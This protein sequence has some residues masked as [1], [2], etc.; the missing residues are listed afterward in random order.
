MILLA[1]CDARYC[2]S[3]ADVGEC[4]SNNDSGVLSNS[5]MGKLFKRN[6]VNIPNPSEIEGTDVELPY[7][8][9]GDEIFTLINWLMRPFSRKPL[10]NEKRKVFNYRLSRARRIIEN[11][12]GILVARWRILQRPIEGTP[13]RVEKYI[14][15]MILYIINLDKRTMLAILQLVFVDSVDSTGELVAGNW[16]K[17]IDNTLQPI[18]PVRNSRYASTAIETR[19]KL[20]DYFVS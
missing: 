11:T 16:R 20:T 13:E 5:Q 4:G 9:E 1:I 3:F 19:E 2:I 10:I 18:R 15:A 6:E 8:L 12:F 7:F 14:L 17:L